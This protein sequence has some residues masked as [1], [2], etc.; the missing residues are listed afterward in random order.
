M[1]N[2]KDQFKDASVY[3]NC[4]DPQESQLLWFYFS[5]KFESLGLRKLVATC[6]KTI[7]AQTDLFTAQDSDH[8]MAVV[9]ERGQHIR[10]SKVTLKLKGDGDFRSPECVAF[11]R[12]ATHVV[13]NPP[14]SLFREYMAQ[15]IEHGVKF[16]VVGNMNVSNTKAIFPLI[17]DGLVWYGSSMGS[18]ASFIRGDTKEEQY[19]GFSRWFTNMEHR[20][21]HNEEIQLVKQYSPMEF[22]FYDN[23]K[24][25]INV[26]KYGHIPAD[27]DG[28]M[29]VP[30]SFL[31]HH[32]PKQFEIV[33]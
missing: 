12:E 25:V 16:C 3:L 30:I 2:Y 23:Y 32:N 26:N 1:A 20:K 22:P 6:Y 11:L 13:T 7:R 14:F 29:G 33:G 17:R 28:V 18:G 27:F 4:D 5:R 15:L 31:D 24:T 9:M 19:L 21:R 8:G 10:M